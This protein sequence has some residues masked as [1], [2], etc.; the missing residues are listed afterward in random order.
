MKKQN[1]RCEC[2]RSKKRVKYDTNLTSFAAATDTQNE[3]ETNKPSRD[4]IKQMMDCDDVVD[5]T[6]Q[7]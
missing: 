4:E 2:K 5:D 6:L 3:A 1:T 7:Q